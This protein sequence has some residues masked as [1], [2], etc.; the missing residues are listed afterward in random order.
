[1]KATEYVK[2]GRWFVLR[3]AL[4]EEDSDSVESLFKENGTNKHNYN[5]NNL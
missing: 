3:E 1:M 5:K 4:P 2:K